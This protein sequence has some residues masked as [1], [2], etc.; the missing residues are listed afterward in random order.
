V[1]SDKAEFVLVKIAK[2]VQKQIFAFWPPIA[3]L[4][5]PIGIAKT[6]KFACDFADFTQSQIDV[7]LTKSEQ[8]QIV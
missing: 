5:Y 6:F 8:K 2:V 1:F 3:N 7:S 4:Q